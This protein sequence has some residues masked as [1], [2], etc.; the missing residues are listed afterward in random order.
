[1]AANHVVKMVASAGT[2]QKLTL[3]TRTLGEFRR[4]A[5]GPPCHMCSALG[6]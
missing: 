4:D 6:W 2:L 3:G 1:M 5:A